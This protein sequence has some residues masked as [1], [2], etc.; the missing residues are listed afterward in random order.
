M[1]KLRS[2]DEAEIDC[3][4]NI[5]KVMQLPSGGG[6]AAAAPEFRRTARGL[7]VVSLLEASALV[8]GTCEIVVLESM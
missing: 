6:I 3:R 7:I 5:N 4:I 1:A 8:Q 2:I